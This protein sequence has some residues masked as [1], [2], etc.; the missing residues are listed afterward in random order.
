MNGP[1]DWDRSAGVSSWLRPDERIYW[2]GRPDPSVVFAPQ[3]LY[4]VP[5]SLAWS[6]AVVLL[7][8]GAVH[9]GSIFGAV[10]GI[11]FLV[12]GAYLVA[13]RFFVKVWRR[14]HTLYAVTNH[15]AVEVAKG[16]R[17]VREL[18]APVHV[19]LRP[20]P[21]AD[22]GTMIFEPL[23]ASQPIQRRWALRLPP[24]LAP[25]VRGT[26]W[27]GAGSFDEVC[28]FDVAGFQSLI[29]AVR[30]AGFDLSSE[31]QATPAQRSRQPPPASRPATA[32]TWF[33]TRLG[34]VP[35]SL[36]SPLPPEEVAAR[37]VRDLAPLRQFDVGFG[38]RAPYRRSI[39]GARVR[40]MCMGSSMQNS[41][42]LV[43]DGTIA[44]EGPGTR[45]TGSLGPNQVTV[46]FSAVWIGF[47]GLFFLGGL[48]GLFVKLASG[49]TPV[50]FL[51]FVLIPG[52]M[53][54]GFFGLTEIATRSAR[55]EWA[56]M[57]KWLRQLLAVPG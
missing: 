28:F 30:I 57:D 56:M 23:L 31:L 17:V 18:S 38:R 9:D 35:Y 19:S 40:L 3:D 14:L 8:R 16:G 5:L 55:A 24:A 44:P 53:T 42:R 29:A 36:W 45:L 54:A 41:W 15:R 48:I 27:P 46:V 33:R 50:A 7:E 34:R 52:A 25:Y 22:T 10:W 4:L 47:V 12:V 49:H 43:F 37:L 11:A 13:G 51:P 1:S 21:D 39:S 20:K 2:R 32:R 26:V 6:V